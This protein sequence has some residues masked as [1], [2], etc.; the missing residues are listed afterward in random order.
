MSSVGP[1]R[2]SSSAA[3]SAFEFLL[4][5]HGAL[6]VEDG[7]GDVA[8]DPGFFGSKAAFDH[9][10]KDFAHDAVDGEFCRESRV[11]PSARG[12]WIW[13]TYTEDGYGMRA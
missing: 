4:V 5:L 11:Q 12:R 7:C 6:C 1:L 3:F 8:E 13:Q 2:R 9:G 10:L